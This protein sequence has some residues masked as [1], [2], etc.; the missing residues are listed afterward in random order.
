MSIPN[1]YPRE[2][3]GRFPSWPLPSLAAGERIEAGREAP[4]EDGAGTGEPPLVP[5]EGA[6]SGQLASRRPAGSPG[7]VNPSVRRGR[8]KEVG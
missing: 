3:A 4:G 7:Y 1:V 8:N 5:V 2:E 6:D